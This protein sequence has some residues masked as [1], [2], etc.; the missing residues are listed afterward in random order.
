MSEKFESWHK[1]SVKL[2]MHFHGAVES[3]REML[4]DAVLSGKSDNRIDILSG[5]M[6]ELTS[7]IATFTLI[8]EATGME[9]DK[10]LDFLRI[11]VDREIAKFREFQ[12]RS[13]A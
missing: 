5:M 4:V 1:N 2:R 13:P 3:A 10:T 6:A 8:G 9:C 12:K 7:L 11:Q